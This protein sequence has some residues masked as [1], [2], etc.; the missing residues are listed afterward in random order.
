MTDLSI[1]K[2]ADPCAGELKTADNN[3]S[4][5]TVSLIYFS[6]L[7]DHVNA[8]CSDSELNYETCQL[9]REAIRDLPFTVINKL[10]FNPMLIDVQD[11]GESF[12]TVN[13]RVFLRQ[14]LAQGRK[15]SI[16]T[17]G[18]AEVEKLRE[19]I[20]AELTSYADYWHEKKNSVCPI[21]LSS[22]ARSANP[23]NYAALQKHADALQRKILSHLIGESLRRAFAG[24]EVAALASLLPDVVLTLKQIFADWKGSSH[25]LALNKLRHIVPGDS[26]NQQIRALR[27][28]LDTLVSVVEVIQDPKCSWVELQLRI[29]QLQ[30]SCQPGQTLQQL[31]PL[32]VTERLHQ[33]LRICALLAEKIA[34]QNAISGALN[35]AEWLTDTAWLNQ[36]LPQNLHGLAAAGGE[37]YR[38]GQAMGTVRKLSPD[39]SHLQQT[40]QLLRL[41]SASGLHSQLSVY[42]GDQLDAVFSTLSGALTTLDTLRRLPQADAGTLLSGLATLLADSRLAFPSR[43]MAELTT[44]AVL[45]Q[46]QVSDLPAWPADDRLQQ[47][48]WLMAVVNILATSPGLAGYLSPQFGWLLSLAQQA[49]SLGETAFAVK[50]PVGAAAQASWLTGLLSDT[51]VNHLLQMLLPETSFQPVKKVM[52]RLEQGCMVLEKVQ[53]FPYQGSRSQQAGWILQLMAWPQAFGMLEMI[54]PGHFGAVA[55][56]LQSLLQL[57]QKWL[58]LPPDASWAMTLKA[59]SDE[60]LALGQQQIIARPELLLSV[61]KQYPQVVILHAAFNAQASMPASLTRRQ[62]LEFIAYEMANALSGNWIL[63]LRSIK[64]APTWFCAVR[65][66]YRWYRDPAKAEQAL[67]HLASLLRDISGHPLLVKLLPALP[68]LYEIWRRFDLPAGALYTWRDLSQLV[69]LA[70]NSSNSALQALMVE[71]EEELSKAIAA[72]LIR[73]FDRV[74]DQLAAILPA[75]HATTIMPEADVP[76]ASEVKKNIADFLRIQ[77]AHLLDDQH[78]V[79]TPPARVVLEQH[80]AA[81]TDDY[82]RDYQ[83]L[84]QNRHDAA[85]RALLVAPRELVD[86]SADA[87]DSPKYQQDDEYWHDLLFCADLNAYQF[88]DR[89]QITGISFTGSSVHQLKNLLQ[90]EPPRKSEF[91]AALQDRAIVALQSEIDSYELDNLCEEVFIVARPLLA[92][93]ITGSA[94]STYAEWYKSMQQGK[95]FAPVTSSLSHHELWFRSSG[96]EAMLDLFSAELSRGINAAVLAALKEVKPGIVLV[97]SADV[98]KLADIYNDHLH[99]INEY[100]K[101][102]NYANIRDHIISE[103]IQAVYDLGLSYSWQANSQRLETFH[104]PLEE[105][106]QLD[107]A[108]QVVID[109]EYKSY[110][111]RE[112]AMGAVF[113]DSGS[114]SS[115]YYDW[116]HGGSAHSVAYVAKL[117]E[118]PGRVQERLQNVFAKLKHDIKAAESIKKLF[119]LSINACLY[120]VR[121]K[122]DKELAAEFGDIIDGFI[123]GEIAPEFLTIQSGELS[124]II[125]LKGKKNR[126][127]LISAMDG[128]FNIVNEMEVNTISSGNARKLSV[129]DKTDIS[130]EKLREWLS[131]HLL[132]AEQEKVDVAFMGAKFDS[133]SMVFSLPKKERNYR[134][135]IY[136]V[137]A[138]YRTELFRRYI[139]KSA[140]DAD[141]SIKTQFEKDVDRVL[142]LASYAAGALAFGMPGT[143]AGRLISLFLGLAVE[144][145]IQV[146]KFLNADT[147]DEKDQAIWAM[148]FAGATGMLFDVPVVAKA[149]RNRLAKQFLARKLTDGGKTAVLPEAVTKATTRAAPLDTTYRLQELVA[150]GKTGSI[151]QLEAGTFIKDYK[152][153]VIAAKALSES[154]SAE[155]YS[156]I[157]IEANNDSLAL[158]RFYGPG[159]AMVEIYHGAEVVRG[160]IIIHINK[161]DGDS[162]DTVLKSFDEKK[163]YDL[164]YFLSDEILVNKKII[165]LF[166]R[167][168]QNGISLDNVR[169][170]DI[171]FDN[172][173]KTLN[174][175]NFDGVKVRPKS[176]GEIIPLSSGELSKIKMDFRLERIKLKRQLDKIDLLDLTINNDIPLEK[177]TGP[178]CI[179]KRGGKAA[180]VVSPLDMDLLKAKEK[181]LNDYLNGYSYQ[182]EM[183]FTPELRRIRKVEDLSQYD[184]DIEKTLFRAH[185]AQ[186]EDI[187]KNGLLRR[188]SLNENRYLTDFDIYLRDIFLHVGS[189]GTR[190]KALSLSTTRRVSESFLQDAEARSLVKIG[191]KDSEKG[192]FMSTPDIIKTYGG[193]ALDKNLISDEEIC[194]SLKS[195][196]ASFSEREVFFMGKYSGL[197]WGELPV[198]KCSVINAGNGI[199]KLSC[200]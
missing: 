59:I 86:K 63:L 191:I 135:I 121:N 98:D 72:L 50:A 85:V 9:I 57:H 99:Q 133:P 51:A 157:L 199:R 174:L 89:V 155:K 54:C 130:D 123:K 188:V 62:Q 171:L 142:D 27:L 158:N 30:Q 154:D 15:Q 168:K 58:A 115:V 42:L 184:Y 70:D 138:D 108:M 151:Y 8:I 134:P 163:F 145:A 81:L 117:W 197:K 144:P 31:L 66:C 39:A 165:E 49:Q 195:L 25:Q 37:I 152:P 178:R 44:S 136:T 71:M 166:S 13:N 80:L 88:L 82:L 141:A 68:G 29:G 148:L 60:L 119:S 175:L 77:L 120:L 169:W 22:T 150:Q 160:N 110:T 103:E 132:Y 143:L 161:I 84:Y 10:R 93:W 186:K 41:I 21:P 35:Y 177:L 64:Q 20:I 114:F 19:A 47:S 67:M 113:K 90:P 38:I 16:D 40:E 28:L 95:A 128:N 109:N 127:L 111:M 79:I 24:S 94:M 46:Q 198:R 102:Y 170:Q 12:D 149:L 180:C 147:H 107:T 36:L 140:A 125:A 167:L 45:L 56:K 55:D 159:S 14:L 164:K 146:S 78:K 139:N 153:S 26:A 189:N 48:L 172:Q 190:G 92:K 1:L 75:A 162:I 69:M 156:Q 7:H 73:S 65:Q 91:E 6:Q 116:Q 124:Q 3:K 200:I 187:V 61:L 104:E 118:L 100:G 53:T 4:A 173:K 137:S 179:V 97:K 105:Q 33:G 2:F 83:T 176:N 181:M 5:S 193:Y 183:K 185:T 23:Q 32:A 34:Q 196:E 87:S 112:I 18:E 43:L 122:L 11:S 96:Q 76:L 129:F 74:K 182:F 194:N 52:D 101:R 131:R 126:R 106:L 192:R 17:V